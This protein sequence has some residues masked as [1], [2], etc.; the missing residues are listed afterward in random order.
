MYVLARSLR[1][2]RERDERY[3]SLVEHLPLT[4]YRMTIDAAPRVVYSARRS[5]LCSG[6]RPARSSTVDDLMELIHPDDRERVQA[7]VAHVVATG[8]DL[9]SDAG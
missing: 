3:R 4:T 1:D 8:D 6:I 5:T 9:S 2:G 7:D